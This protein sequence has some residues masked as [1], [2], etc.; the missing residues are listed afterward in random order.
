MVEKPWEY[1]YPTE[2]LPQLNPTLNSYITLPPT[3]PPTLDAQF[4]LPFGLQ[5]CRNE[6]FSNTLCILLPHYLHRLS[7]EAYDA[8]LMSSQ[9]VWACCVT[10]HLGHL[11]PQETENKTL[12]TMQRFFLTT[13]P[14]HFKLL[15]F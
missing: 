5:K 3:N 14:S 10:V 9:Q 11:S 15:T 2:H 8:L 12:D 6:H 1:P 7:T 4:T 13:V